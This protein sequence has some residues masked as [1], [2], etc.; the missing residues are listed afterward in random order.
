MGLLSSSKK[1]TVNNDNRTINDLSNSNFDFSENIDGDFN[2]NTGTINMID[3]NAIAGALALSEGAMGLA[4]NALTANTGVVTRAMDN[5]A[6]LTDSAMGLANSAM[7]NNAYLTDSVI[8]FADSAMTNNAHLADSSMTNSAYLAEIGMNN[9]A[10]MADSS[11]TNSAYLADSAMTNN[12]FLADSTINASRGMLSDSLTFGMDTTNKMAA[13]SGDALQ[14]TDN[15]SARGINAA[16]AIHESAANQ[17]AQGNELAYALATNARAQSAENTQALGDGFE[18]AMQFV[19]GF[20]R[21]DGAAIAE[22][23][24]KYMALTAGAVLIAV[25]FFKG[26]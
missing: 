23:N 19:E 1:T 17:V 4:D 16:L 14:L 2:K 5:S 11:M 9:A 13:F 20:S 7:T 8:G 24:A 26:K 3:P 6:Y 18:Q 12:A 21:S 10:Y 25:F 22:S 15:M